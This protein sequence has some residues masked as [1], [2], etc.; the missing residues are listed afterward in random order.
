MVTNT[1]LVLA[2]LLFMAGVFVTI[3]DVILFQWARENNFV[4]LIFGLL[5]NVAG[6][7]FYAQ[8]LKFESLGL[9]TAMFLGL[10]I[11]AVTLAGCFIFG[12]RIPLKGVLGMGL[13]AIS[14]FL[15]EI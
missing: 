4:H 8:A 6:I 15:I 7:T 1:K 9:A 14:I 11:L 5:F 12:E 13:I 2:T 10:N 3:G